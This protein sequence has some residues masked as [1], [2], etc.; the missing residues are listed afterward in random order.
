[1]MANRSPD[2]DEA[3][4][5]QSL[6]SRARPAWRDTAAHREVRRKEN[7]PPCAFANSLPHEHHIT[8]S[9]MLRVMRPPISG[10]SAYGHDA[11]HPCRRRPEAS[12]ALGA[13][14]SG[15]RKR[16]GTGASEPEIP[17]HGCRSVGCARRWTR[18]RHVFSAGISMGFS[19]Y[20]ALVFRFRQKNPFPEVWPGERHHRRRAMRHHLQGARPAPSWCRCSPA[21]RCRQTSCPAAGRTT[22]PRPAS[23][24][25]AFRG[26]AQ[27]SPI[28]GVSLGSCQQM[29]APRASRA[30][31]S[32]IRDEQAHL[33]SS[34]SDHA[35]N[36]GRFRLTS[37]THASDS[38]VGTPTI[39]C[40]PQQGVR[41]LRL[42]RPGSLRW[43]TRPRKKARGMATSS[44][45]PRAV[46]PL[47]ARHSRQKGDDRIAPAGHQRQTDCT[48]VGDCQGAD[49]FCCSI[50]RQNARHED[51]RECAAQRR[52]TFVRHPHRR[53]DTA[54][55]SC[56]DRTRANAEDFHSLRHQQIPNDQIGC[57]RTDVRAAD[58]AGAGRDCCDRPGSPRPRFRPDGG[59]GL[60]LCHLRLARV[61]SPMVRGHNVG[62]EA[63][64][65]SFPHEV[66]RPRRQ[67]GAPWR[68][69]RRIP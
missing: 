35:K 47:V 40:R 58:I 32:D 2:R 19:G 4:K 31:V 68:R 33:C 5:G 10:T 52:T 36:A 49:G 17:F 22:H 64:K 29:A 8:L 27:A 18:L 14:A 57:R 44:L 15:N 20:L 69:H 1:M 56:V 48:K 9:S 12:L 62:F 50:V 61:T 21:T 55:Q 39:T 23:V 28:I 63:R 24:S 42:G 6:V 26:G 45:A 65:T 53:R 46:C 25:G 66:A 67:T 43:P 37:S 30:A 34:S 59:A 11:V 54:D 38:K 7:R 13:G 51:A 60:W 16:I 41:Q 3:G